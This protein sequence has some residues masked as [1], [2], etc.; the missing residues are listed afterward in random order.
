MFKNIWASID[1]WWFYL[2]FVSYEERR[3]RLFRKFMKRMLRGKGIKLE[4]LLEKSKEDPTWHWWTEFQWS[5]E[6]EEKFKK[7][8][9]KKVHKK[10]GYVEDYSSK[11]V[12]MFLLQ[13][14]LTTMHDPKWKEFPF[15]EDDIKITKKDLLSLVDQLN[16][17]N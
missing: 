2:F 8:A 13:Y 16:R 10:L 5:C 17:E 3:E 7:W 11:V 12:G 1:N 15:S 9:V 14:G 4:E 6:E